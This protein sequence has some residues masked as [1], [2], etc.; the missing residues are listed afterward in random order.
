MNKADSVMKRYDYP[1]WYLGGH[2]LGGVCA[3][4]Y[5]AGHGDL[6]AGLV[7][8]A[9]YPAKQLPDRL[10]TVLIYGT[11]DGVLD[12]EKYAAGKR[13]VPADAAEYV[14]EGGNHAQFGSY[15]VQDGDGEAAVSP[16]EQVAA[17]VRDI[18]ACV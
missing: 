9:A 14:I 5:A 13:F 1:H 7:L 17:A 15:G 4:D 16:A 10:N 3:A 11:A 2:S 8:L 12:P 18:M 6:L